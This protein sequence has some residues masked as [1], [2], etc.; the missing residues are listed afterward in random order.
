MVDFL[1]MTWPNSI[2]LL[3][4]VSTT[5]ISLCKEVLGD[6]FLIRCNNV[7]QENEMSLPLVRGS[8]D[9]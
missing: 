1:L 2:F 5:T 3:I 9:G 7:V 6:S 4:L 8:L